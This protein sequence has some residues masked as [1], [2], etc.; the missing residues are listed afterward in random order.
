MSRRF[1]TVYSNPHPTFRLLLFIRAGG[2]KQ[3][4]AREVMLP[5]R[6]NVDCGRSIRR[7]LPWLTRLCAGYNG[8]LKGLCQASRRHVVSYCWLLSPGRGLAK[9]G[10]SFCVHIRQTKCITELEHFS[11]NIV[12]PRGDMCRSFRCV[13]YMCVVYA[14]R[15]LML[16]SNHLVCTVDTS[17]WPLRDPVAYIY[18]SLNRKAQQ[19]PSW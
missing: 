11:I 4:L 18:Q 2:P 13:V 6:S 19:L 8:T 17:S 5:I 14:N 3:E 16:R 12:D 15:C 7:N 10:R 9:L 1:S